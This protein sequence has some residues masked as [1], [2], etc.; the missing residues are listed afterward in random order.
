METGT[1]SPCRA[2]ISDGFHGN[3]SPVI[4]EDVTTATS[5]QWQISV[6]GYKIDEIADGTSYCYVLCSHDRTT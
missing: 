3:T 5:K 2:T 6:Q 1:A 4:G